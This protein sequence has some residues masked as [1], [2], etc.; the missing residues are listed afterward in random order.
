MMRHSLPLAM[1]SLLVLAGCA[2]VPEP[3]DI[4]STAPSAPPPASSVQPLGEPKVLA[5]GLESPWSVV[6][7]GDSD[8]TLISERDSGTVVERLP[9]GTLRDVGVVAGVVHAGEGGL[10]GLA[11]HPASSGPGRW[12]YA[13]LTTATDNRIVRMPLTGASGSYRLGE[14]TSILTGLAKAG[15]HDGG[16]IAFGPDGMLYATVGDAGQPSRAQDPASL[17]GKILRMTPTGGVPRDNPTSASLVYSLG[18]RN[19]QGIA[20]DADGQLWAAEFGQ[21]T[22]DEFN[23]IEPG[24]NYG[25]P[26]VEGIGSRSGFVDPLY[27]WP[28]ADAS[29]SGLAFVGGTFFLAALRGERLWAINPGSTT[30]ALPY[31][32][33]D[34]GRLRDAVAGPDGSLWVLTNNTDGRGTPGEGDD[35]LMEV[36]LDASRA[37]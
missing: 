4:S 25:W 7:L 21:N 34:L 35:K 28:T 20:W 17:N 8:S 29:P 23:R 37:G 26:V 32:T 16:R 3:S 9:S 19:P 14:P 5:T 30:T 36:R 2:E 22:W 27:Q 24:G 10:L 18:H 15:N 12:L 13:Y 33:G 6:R 11:V 31:F 1:A